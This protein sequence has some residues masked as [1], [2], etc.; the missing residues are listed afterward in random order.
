MDT[1][2]NPP[3]V[4]SLS[5]ASPGPARLASALG[6][7]PE[8]AET[9][10]R[11]GHTTPEAVAQLPDAELRQA[12][13]SSADVIRLKAGPGGSSAPAFASTTISLPTPK[14]GGKE[15]TGISEF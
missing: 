5:A 1:T 2:A 11:A 13:L 3:P 12:G 6:I 14:P 7:A 9:L 4:A 15:T 10:Y 8:A